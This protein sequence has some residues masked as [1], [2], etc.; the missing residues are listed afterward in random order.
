MHE[1]TLQYFADDGSEQTIRFSAL[2]TNGALDRAMQIAPRHPA[3]LT[4]ENGEICRLDRSSR[5]PVWEISH[6]N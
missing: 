2:S 6:R 5:A 1:Y 3:V 4:D